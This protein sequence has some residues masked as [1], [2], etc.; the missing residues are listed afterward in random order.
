M[1][2]GIPSPK[3]PI[4]PYINIKTGTFG[5]KIDNPTATNDIKL[6]EKKIIYK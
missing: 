3:P 2:D 5:E 4:T 6:P 1:N